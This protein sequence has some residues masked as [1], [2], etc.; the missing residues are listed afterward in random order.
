MAELDFEKHINDLKAKDLE[1]HRNFVKGLG[2]LGPEASQFGIESLI[3]ALAD[4]DLISE[5][6]EALGKIGEP[7]ITPLIQ[8]LSTPDPTKG[9]GISLAL[10]KI[11]KAAIDPLIE[12]LSIA[13]DRQARYIPKI[14][15]GFGEDAI[16][17]V[18]QACND[19]NLKVR[20]R[21]IQIF[22]ELDLK[23]P[24]L[25]ITPII[26]A[27]DD[28][29]AEIRKAAIFALVNVVSRKKALEVA[30][31]ELLIQKLSDLDGSVRLSA[32]L[33]LGALCK[34]GEPIVNL[35]IESLSSNNDDI[36]AGAAQALTIAGKER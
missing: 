26:Q 31:V 17:P 9:F 16:E 33:A 22:G 21:A 27:L 24:S 30:I 11:G 8:A 2:E 3:E 1:N 10:N 20:V 19:N 6:S 5:A 13:E 32:S 4:P 36:R 15:G 23:T 34:I 25:V 35:L 28:K 7:A 18:M 12:I 29:D 14:L